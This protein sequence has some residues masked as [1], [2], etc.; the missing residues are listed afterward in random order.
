MGCNVKIVKEKENVFEK[1]N[2]LSGFPIDK[3]IKEG[4]FAP[5]CSL[6]VRREVF[7]NV[8]LFDRR[9]ISSG[10]LEF[11]NRVHNNGYKLGYYPK[12]KVYHPARSSLKSLIRKNIRIGI[13]RSQLEEYYPNRYRKSFLG[14]LNLV[15]PKLP[16]K[17]G[18]KN[19]GCHSL[20]YKEKILFYLL[21]TFFQMFFNFGYLKMKIED[22][23]I[24]EE[25]KRLNIIEKI[26]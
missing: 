9:L 5:T 19:R 3:Y 11:G 17:M 1:Y 7:S 22:M 12:E 18:K 6:L 24:F 15:S 23:C 21:K 4:N 8:G 26:K 2:K 13:G 10:D 20:S 25:F 16:I 14:F